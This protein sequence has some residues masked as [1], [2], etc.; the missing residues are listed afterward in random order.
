MGR[1]KRH[2]DPADWEDEFDDDLTPQTVSSSPKSSP[3]QAWGG[4]GGER[5]KTQEQ[6]DNDANKQKKNA[7]PDKETELTNKPD[8]KKEKQSKSK[9]PNP[10]QP[11]Q[12]ALPLLIRL[13][14]LI[15]WATALTLIAACLLGAVLLTRELF[16]P[17][18]HWLLRWLVYPAIIA[19]SFWFYL[20]Q[21]QRLFLVHRYAREAVAS[22]WIYLGATVVFV[23]TAAETASLTRGLVNWTII[24]VILISVVV[25][26][27]GIL[28]KTINQW[29]QNKLIDL[30]LMEKDSFV[31]TKLFSKDAWH[32][33]LCA[34]LFFI[35]VVYLT[36]TDLY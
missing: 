5:Q 11:Q 17:D 4:G 16:N 31:P 8:S 26:L 6:I 14:C 19:A 33:K 7:K 25:L 1:K 32:K 15:T 2:S 28:N 9:S 36:T 12:P 27:I 24:K 21:F 20:V 29:R 23:S 30:S 13:S 34:L 22:V 10:S 3:L 18:V 35:L